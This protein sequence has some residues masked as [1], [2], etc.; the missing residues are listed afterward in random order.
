MANPLSRVESHLQLCKRPILKISKIKEEIPLQNLK[1]SRMRKSQCK[2]QTLH[3]IKQE[4]SKKN[5][6]LTASFRKKFKASMHLLVASMVWSLNKSKTSW[7]SSNP[8][9]SQRTRMKFLWSS[10]ANRVF[11]YTILCPPNYSKPWRHGTQWLKTCRNLL[12]LTLKKFPCLTNRI[13]VQM[14][15]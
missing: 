11:V 5:E 2:S 3:R 6:S 13:K 14:R 9:W 8:L 7:K 10:R 15:T 12:I 4:V 1:R